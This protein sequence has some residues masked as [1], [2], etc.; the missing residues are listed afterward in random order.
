MESFIVTP[1][2]SGIHSAVAPRL[3]GGD[4]MVSSDRNAL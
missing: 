2:K 4:E 3:R 1:A